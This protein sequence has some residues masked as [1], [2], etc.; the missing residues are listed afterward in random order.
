MNKGTKQPVKKYCTCSYFHEAFS[1]GYALPF[2]AM[3]DKPRKPIKKEQCEC[4]V[5]FVC[6]Q[7]E[8]GDI[9]KHC[10]KCGKTI[11]DFFPRPDGWE[12]KIKIIC[13]NCQQKT[14][15]DARYNQMGQIKEWLKTHKNRIGNSWCTLEH[16]G[17]DVRSLLLSTRQEDAKVFREMIEAKME[18]H[19]H[20][21]IP[22]FTAGLE[23]GCITCLQNKPYEDLLTAL[24]TWEESNLLQ[25]VE[26]KK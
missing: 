18:L 22:S 16:I 4:K 15:I 23:D 9:G 10:V 12:E 24:S 3:C 20:D 1:G 7:P 2:F 17:I 19:T 11:I 26:G 21:S 6:R 8:C 25:M 13:S 14:T 5:K